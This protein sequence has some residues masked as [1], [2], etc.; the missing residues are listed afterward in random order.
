MNCYKPGQAAHALGIRLALA[1]PAGDISEASIS[2]NLGQLASQIQVTPLFS[3]PVLN[4]WPS[5]W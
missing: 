3:S 4:V 2:P 5:F 1:S